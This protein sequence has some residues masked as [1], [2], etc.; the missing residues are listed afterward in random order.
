M[1]VSE[2]IAAAAVS[3]LEHAPYLP[4][5]APK[6]WFFFIKLKK[7]PADATIAATAVKKDWE[8]VRR[9][10]LKES[11]T[12]AVRRWFERSELFI[13]LQGKYAKNYYKRCFF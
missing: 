13:Q 5:C 7:L 11:V 2:F 1:K 10:S 4:D 3:V 6:D 8:G 12:A 9:S